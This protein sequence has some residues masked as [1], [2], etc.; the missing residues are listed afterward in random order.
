MLRRLIAAI[1]LV[2]LVSTPVVARTRL[3]C[4]FTGEEI[5]DCAEQQIP[6]RSVVQL[7][8]CCNRQVTGALSA[9]LTA[10]Q[11][12]VAPPALIALP[13]PHPLAL[14]D[15]PASNRPICTAAAPT[16]PLVLLITRALLI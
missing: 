13:L 7:E 12:E 2:A 4:R 11:Q 9:L 14:L 8:G 15:L 5:T 1:A 10:Q 6:G 16:G 3:F